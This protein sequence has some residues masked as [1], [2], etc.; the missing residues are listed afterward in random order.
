MAESIKV[1]KDKEIARIIL[2]RPEAFNSFDFEMIDAMARSIVELASDNSVRGIVISGEGKAFCAGGDLKWAGSFPSGPG[3]GFHKL[4][5][6]FHMMIL[7]IRRMGKPVIA[8]IHGVAA[9]GGF[10]IALACDFRV[11]EETATLRQAYTSNGLCI[12]GGGTFTLPR[13]VGLARALEIVAFDAPIPADKALSWG[14][15]TKVVP[16]GKAEEEALNMAHELSHISLDSFT[17]SKQ[18]LTDSFNTSFETQIEH[19]RTGLSACAE[20]KDGREGI[21]A[22]KEKRKPDF[23]PQ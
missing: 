23:V 1:V 3:A 17:W 2:N 6:S 4:A 18:L 7:E 11:M 14:L 10:A 8:A 22:F 19:E 21:Q 16:K 20:S 15:V 9:G 5:A 13:L 12:D